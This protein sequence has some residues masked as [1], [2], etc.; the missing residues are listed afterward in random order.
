MANTSF[1][2]G[3]KSTHS[4]ISAHTAY[5]GKEF[6]NRL[7]EL[8]KD[9]VFNITVLDQTLYYKVTEINVVLPHDAE[10]L[11]IVNGQ[12]LCTLVTCTPYS[13]NSHRLLVRGSRIYPKEMTEKEKLTFTTQQNDNTLLFIITG[14]IGIIIIITIIVI[15]L[16]HRK[17]CKK[18]KAKS[19]MVDN[20]NWMLNDLREKVKADPEC[21]KRG[22]SGSGCSLIIITHKKKDGGKNEKE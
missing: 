15:I 16:V 20:M 11:K 12:D 14:I 13:I 21:I 8:E 4:V 6:F 3:G 17:K 2:I 10:K 18:N 1:P 22:N 9:D 7:T 5:P 19:K